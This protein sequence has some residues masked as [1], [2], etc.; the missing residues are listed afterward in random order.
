[1]LTVAAFFAIWFIR[2][3][4][5]LCFS[6]IDVVTDATERRTMILT[7]LAMAMEGA[8]LSQ[9]IGSLLWQH[10]FRFGLRWNCKG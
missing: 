8:D 2:F 10:L 7:H 4:L 1:M 5:R 9:M 3:M 6:N